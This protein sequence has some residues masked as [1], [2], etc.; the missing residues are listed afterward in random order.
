MRIA[1]YGK[2]PG[3][4]LDGC[5]MEV[6]GDVIEANA[7]YARRYFVSFRTGILAGCQSVVDEDKLVFDSAMP[8]D[9]TL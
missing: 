7:R 5:E 4:L 2:T 3:G 1:H 8:P 6:H 9:A